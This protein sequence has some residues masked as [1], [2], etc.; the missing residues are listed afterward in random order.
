MQQVEQLEGISDK[1]M[2]ITEM[3]RNRSGKQ[4]NRRADDMK[5]ML[6]RRKLNVRKGG[7]LTKYRQRW[8]RVVYDDG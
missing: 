5:D 2:N 7:E 8:S 1:R 6:V 3:Y 4:R